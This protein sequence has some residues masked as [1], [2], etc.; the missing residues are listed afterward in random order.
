V[1][2]VGRAILTGAISAAVIA[3]ALAPHAQA[4]RAAKPKEAR[5]IEKGFMKPR[6]DIETNV[7]KVRI[8]T[9]DK[10]FAA[11]TYD[12]TLE[13]LEPIGEEE[14]G[15]TGRARRERKT[16]EAP[17]PV[18]LKK[19]GGK[20]KTVPKVPGKV[21]KDLKGKPKPRIDITGETA[22]VLS[23]QASCTDNPDFYSANVYD[24]VGDVYLSIDMFRYGG[25]GVYGAYA[26]NTLASLSVGNMG[27]VPQWETGQGDDAFA[28][29]GAIYVDPGG[30]GI[31]TATMARTGGVYP[32]SVL[33]DGFWACK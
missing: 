16:Y 15:S 10:K 29:S 26:V 30:W 5:A 25:P 19:K 9:V 33:V 11:V 21:K 27:G 28:S 8:S 14:I 12:V 32:Q 3:G 2:T 24:P 17:V 18:F 13:E 1:G 22:A 31:I 23:I 4:S 7:E 6:D 20:W